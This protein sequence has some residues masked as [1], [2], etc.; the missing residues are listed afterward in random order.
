MD[1]EDLAQAIARWAS[2]QGSDQAAEAIDE[3]RLRFLL[4]ETRS[5]IKHRSKLFRVAS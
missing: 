2:H 5:Q 1:T 4:K 3:L